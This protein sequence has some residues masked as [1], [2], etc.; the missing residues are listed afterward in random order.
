MTVTS[1]DDEI[2]VLEQKCAESEDKFS[3]LHE[4]LEMLKKKP[5]KANVPTAHK[6]TQTASRP[7]SPGS[8]DT[9]DEEERARL[10]NSRGIVLFYVLQSPKVT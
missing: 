10:K 4:K 1:L 9:T 2:R 3:K 7:P 5:A 6:Q 8:D